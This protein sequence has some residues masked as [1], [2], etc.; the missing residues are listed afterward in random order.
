MGT[1]I[2]MIPCI[3]S[4][5]VAFQK[6]AR[7]DVL[8]P[9]HQDQRTKRLLIHCH[10]LLSWHERRCSFFFVG[11]KNSRRKNKRRW[12]C[13]DLCT[14]RL[15]RRMRWSSNLFRCYARAPENSST[16]GFAVSKKAVSE[17]SM[18][19]LLE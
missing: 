5:L 17:S 15:I 16:I 9:R 18:V 7:S 1:P 14:P 11:L 10:V 2:P 13:F 12:H 8:V 3:G 19:L 6:G 4:L